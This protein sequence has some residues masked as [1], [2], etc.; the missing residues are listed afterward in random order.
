[1][2]APLNPPIRDWRGQRVWLV[3]ASSGIG[4][5]LAAE[6]MRLGARVALSARRPAALAEVAPRAAAPGSAGEAPLLLPLDVTDTAAV[7]DAHD[8]ILAEWGGIDVPVWLAGTY[9][10]MRAHAFD[11]D[12]A[13]QLLDTNLA[14]FHGLSV[15][16]PTLR[17]QGRGA[18]AIVSSVAGYRGL[19]NSLVYG[20]S[21]AALNNLADALY[22]DLHPLGVGVHLIC[23]GFVDTPLTAL[24]DFRMPGLIAPEA[25]ARHIV[26]GFAR[27]RYEI[28]FPAGFT[29]VMRLLGMLP[30]RLYF[31]L[32]RRF[33][34][35]DH[36]P[37][38]APDT[39]SR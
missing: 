6:L 21:K 2:F 10:P 17:R 39:P 37:A 4:A 36:A 1:M 7:R 27:G 12:A 38:H 19:P 26:D 30:H 11:R 16:L 20:P 13:Q 25:A 14:I 29:L 15:L 3:G 31:A 28:R 32:V 9:T 24:N 8:R 22:L 35:S 18:L 5:A 33:T 34:G 23:P